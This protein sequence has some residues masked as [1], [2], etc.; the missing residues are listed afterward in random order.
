[1]KKYRSVKI[2]IMVFAVIGLINIM[3]SSII[4][5][6]EAKKVRK[7]STDI[8]FVP[9][10]SLIIP[11]LHDENPE[12]IV[13]EGLTMNELADKLDKNL[14]STLKGYGKTFAK[15]SI[16]YEVDP[17]VATSIVLLET[18]CKWKCSTLVKK[19]NNIGGMKGQNKCSGSS[20]AKFSSLDAGIE[21]FFKNLSN[22]Y[23]KKGL[24]TT[25]EMNKKYAENPYWYKKVDNYVSQIKSS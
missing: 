18:G 1:M 15:Y 5:K 11:D 23:Y 25:K 8:A 12:E 16:E 9:T 24:T 10:S 2:I 3:T 19:C 22:N 6:D 14:N 7:V 17:Y 21:A 4:M 13:Y 20:Y